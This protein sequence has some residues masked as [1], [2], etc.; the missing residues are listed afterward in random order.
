MN[1]FENDFNMIIENGYNFFPCEFCVHPEM[2]YPVSVLSAE[3]M[4]LVINSV[5]EVDSNLHVFDD[6]SIIPSLDNSF[7]IWIEGGPGDVVTRRSVVSIDG[8]RIKY[9]IIWY[10]WEKEGRTIDSAREVKSMPFSV[11]NYLTV[12]EHVKKETLG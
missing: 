3:N 4:K 5:K 10:E 8:D 11:E 9:T 1:K 12:L 6:F 2:N 7:K